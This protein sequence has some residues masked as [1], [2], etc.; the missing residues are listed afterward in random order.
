MKRRTPAAAHGQQGAATLVVVMVLFLVMALLAAYAN[1]SLMFEQRIASSYARAS[2]A[3]EVAEGGIEWAVAQLNGPAIDASCKPTA[4]AGQRFADKYIPIDP[5]DRS[6]TPFNSNNAVLADCTRDLANDG[7]ACRCA[8]IGN[9]T[10]PAAMG[11]DALTP[12]FGIAMKAGSRG[13]T[14]KVT[15]TGCTGSVV[16]RCVFGSYFA[17]RS[18]GQRA[19]STL[20]AT[21]A[22]VGAVRTPPASPLVVKGNLDMTGTG[23]GLHNTDPRSAGALLAIGGAWTGMNDERMQTVPGTELEEVRAQNQPVLRDAT[24]GDD[25]FKMY[26]G[27]RG[28]RYAQHPALRTVTCDGSDCTDTLA[29]AY[30]AGKRILWVDGPLQIGSNTTLGT[31]SDPVLVIARDVTLSGPFQLNGMLVA[32][33]NLS[34]TN[35]GTQ[36]SV[37]TGIVLVTGNM[38]T[39]G[40]MD[41]AY[42]QAIADQLRNRMGSYVRVPGSWID[43]VE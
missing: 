15:S 18:L 1:R 2:L 39:A 7:W 6:I 25:V 19:N 14:L 33:G 31:A 30:A 9:R 16:D 43:Q 32:R 11:G 28:A 10:V 8:T 42:Q 40:K 29:T 36:P 22:L 4:T 3:Q 38:Q 37:V 34:W 35:S 12:S 23:L 5:S 20:A 24:S 21:L 26:M 13:G 27:A 17:D 41:I